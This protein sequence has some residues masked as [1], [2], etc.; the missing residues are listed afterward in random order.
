MAK[1]KSKKK[2]VGQQFLSDSEYVRQKARTLKIGKCYITGQFDFAGEGYVIVTRLHTGGN[3][4]MGVFLVDKFCLGVKG[5]FYRLRIGPLDLHDFLSYIETQVG[6]REVSYDEAHN[7]IY[8]AVAFAEE[9]GIKP[10]KEFGL[11]SCMLEEDDDKI[12]LIEYEY[13]KGGMHYLVAHTQREADKYLPTLRKHL[14]DRFDYVIDDGEDDLDDALDDYDDGDTD[15]QDSHFGDFDGP[16]TKYTYKHPEYPTELKLEN[17]MVKDLLYRDT[18]I[19]KDELERLLA[20]PHDSLRRDLENLLMYTL[21][22]FYDERQDYMSDD[23]FTNEVMSALV[24]LGEV[25]TEADSLGVVLETLR[26]PDDFFEFHMADYA[27]EVFVPTLYLLGNGRLDLLMGFMKE[28][29]LY[30]FAKVYVS[31]VM[32]LLVRVQPER[33]GEAI[34]WMREVLRFAAVKLPETQYIDGFL[35]G[36]LAGVC[37]DL[38]AEELLQELKA[39]FDTCLVDTGAAGDYETVKFEIES[40][41]DPYCEDYQLDVRKRFAELRKTLG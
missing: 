9:A 14:G 1:N 4:S 24:L 15:F 36:M 11:V 22:R 33:R 17:G 8:G 3:V 26:Q 5:A 2:N 40:A 38:K 21:G 25:G 31:S 34:E 12:P 29:G 37:I 20:L 13:G 27:T 19:A 28:E 23:G 16:V 30:P 39:M 41:E 7:I 6:L 10:C 18:I 35:A 32:P